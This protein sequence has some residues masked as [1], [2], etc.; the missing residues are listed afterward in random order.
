GWLRAGLGRVSGMLRE[1]DPALTAIVAEGFFSRLSFGL[2]SFALPLYAHREFGL[3]LSEIGI[4]LALNMA[5]AV[6]LKPAA[7]RLIDRSGLKLSLASAIALRSV[8]SGLLA[9]ASAPWHLY[10]IRA[11]HGVSISLRDPS[12]AVLLSDHGRTAVA[13]VFAWYQ[14]AKS[15]AG[16]LGRTAAGL[17]L[18]LTA[19]NYGL[20]FGVAFVL[21]ALPLLVVLRHVREA[22]AAEP[23][24]AAGDEL[25]QAGTWSSAAAR[26]AVLPFAFLGFLISGTAYM[27]TGLFPI[28]AVE[29]AGLS[30]A[31]AGLVYLIASLFVLSGPVFGLLS[32]KVSR[33]LVLSVRS[34]A[35]VAS[36]VLYLIAPS[37]IGVL[38]GRVL[39]DVGKAAFRPAW[40]AL[41]AEIAGLDRRRRARTV[42]ALSAGED[43]GEIAGPIAAGFLWSMWGLPVL[44][45]ARIVLAVLTEL[46][47]VALTGRWGDPA[48][49]LR[50]LWRAG[51]L[52]ARSAWRDRSERRSLP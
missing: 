29:H 13:S 52:R 45:A 19:A 12:A 25:R 34:A 47:A 35:N 9:L 44:L 41:M 8:V 27:L 5:V 40:G 48:R 33:N 15:L 2:I 4:L 43:A 36:S 49:L 32:D 18:T 10:A 24:P 22:P 1:V 26:P 31:E 16:A 7:G 46:Y 37:F 14:T 51:Q 3:G 11:M 30:E 42:S 38:A 39:D 17:L 6:A 20:I 28:F 21:S 50:A 23:R